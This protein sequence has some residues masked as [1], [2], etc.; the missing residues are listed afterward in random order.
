MRNPMLTVVAALLLELSMTIGASAQPTC[1]VEVAKA[2]WNAIAHGSFLRPSQRILLSNGRVVAGSLI[3]YSRVLIWRAEHACESGQTE[4]A[5]DYINEANEL[6]E[7]SSA[8][9]IAA[10]RSRK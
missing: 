8:E 10:S 5:R 7:P 6:L 3:N 4:E 1:G 9:L 2:E